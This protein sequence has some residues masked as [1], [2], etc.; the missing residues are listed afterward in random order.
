VL[1]RSGVDGNIYEAGETS[2]EFTIQS[3]SKAFVFGLAVLN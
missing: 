2:A 3:I 1:F